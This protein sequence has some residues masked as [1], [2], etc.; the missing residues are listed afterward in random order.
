[1]FQVFS[2]D[3]AKVDPVVAYVTMT[4][5]VCC[6][7]MFRVFQWFRHMFQ[8]FHLNVTE[9]YLDVAEIYLDVA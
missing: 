6:K 4:I 8:V 1:M 2:L 5:Y 3:V 7:Y 9:I